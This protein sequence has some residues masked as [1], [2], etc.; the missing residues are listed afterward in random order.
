MIAALLLGLAEIE[1][2]YRQER[3]AAGI[4]GRQAEGHLQGAAAGNDQSRPHQ[5]EAVAGAGTDRC[6]DCDRL[7]DEQAD[8]SAVFES[9]SSYG[10]VVANLRIGKLG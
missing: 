4:R 10:I 1:L 3:Q 8:G 5:G 7:G 6:R 2:E 9:Q